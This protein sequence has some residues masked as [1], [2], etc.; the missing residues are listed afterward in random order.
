M[1]VIKIDDKDYDSE[2]LSNEAKEML[3]NIQI[4]DQEIQ[5]LNIQL[6]LARTAR[7]SYAE[8]LK[9]ALK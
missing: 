7:N 9:K 6:A 1:P 2:K 5:R 4:A 3:A 8:K